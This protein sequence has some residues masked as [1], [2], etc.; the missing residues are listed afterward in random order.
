M[1]DHSGIEALQRIIDRYLEAN[2]NVTLTHLSP[3][4]IAILTKANP[5]FDKYIESS[6][7]DPRYHV[8]T[9]LMEAEA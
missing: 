4:R 2:K 3:E 7:E 9:D 5:A 1:S 8:V 6:V